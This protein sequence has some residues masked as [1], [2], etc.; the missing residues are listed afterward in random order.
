MPQ[1]QKNKGDAARRAED[2]ARQGRERFAPKP[3]PV[4]E[5][6]A[7]DEELRHALRYGNER[8]DAD[9]ALKFLKG[10]YVYD[11]GR[12]EVYRHIDGSHYEKDAKGQIGVDANTCL[13]QEFDRYEKKLLATLN[14]PTTPDNELKEAGILL[15]MTKRRINAIN[16]RSRIK[17]I[18]QFIIEGADSIAITSDSWNCDP[19]L[20]PV[21]NGV[22]NLKTFTFRPST[23]DDLFCKFAPT[24]FVEGADAPHF[25]GFISSCL[26]GNTNLVRYVQKILGSAIVGHSKQQEFYV[27][28][29][30]GRNG[31]GT[32]FATRWRRCSSARTRS[33]RRLR[34]SIQE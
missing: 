30:E 3:S 2:R 24:D 15:K 29:G 8:A 34:R 26:D 10:P 31:K 17:N 1:T 19:W 28:Y 14:D 33:P 6:R 18:M 21:K 23:P 7:A 22:Y 12:K 25:R 13:I 9:I 27:F 32:T 11:C 5:V 4:A 20:L 16:S